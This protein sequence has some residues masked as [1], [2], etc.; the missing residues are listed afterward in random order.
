MK[1]TDYYRYADKVAKGKICACLYVRQACERFICDLKRKDLIFRKDK[2]DRGLMFINTLKHFAGKSSGNPFILEPFQAFIVANLLGW[3]WKKTGFRRFTS[4]YIEMARKGGKTA[5][6]AALAMYF[7]LGDEEDAAEVDIAAND[8]DQAKICFSFIQQYSRQL[9]SK[10]KYLKVLRSSVEMPMNASKVN[11]F[12]GNDKGKD[13]F[14]AS[15]GIIDEYHSAPNT[16]MRDVI[17]SSMGMRE[18]PMLLTITSAGFDKTLPCYALRTTCAEILKGLKTDDS[19]FCIIFTLDEEDDWRDPGVWVKSNPNLGKTVTE[20]Y[21]REQVNSAINNPGEELSVRTKNLGQWLSSAD[22]WIPEHYIMGC[23][24]DVRLE[25]FEG[26][27]VWCGAD[28]AVV[29][30]MT[31]F[32]YML[33]REDDPKLY[34]KT[35]YYLPESALNDSPNKDKYM[36]WK[37]NGFLKLTPGN[38]TDYQWITNDIMETSR[39]MMIHKIFYDRYNAVSWVTQCTELGL[40][41]EE[42]SQTLGNFNRPTREFERLCRSDGLVIDN[43][44]ITRW[45]FTNVALKHDHNGNAKPDKGLGRARKIDGVISML[46]ALGGYL[47]TPAVDVSIY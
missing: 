16:R 10:G 15:V 35:I 6:I 21:L 12:S 38:V 43:N 18:N 30:D 40:P 23:S 28:L 7:F 36:G 47:I 4:A 22:I 41:M 3:Y 31:A 9:D 19:L 46:E 11:V 34:F 8:F 27:D 25:D 37:R 17:K 20:K 5:L 2:V 24:A 42:Y 1:K 14:N 26:A 33:K 39:G 45:M 13:G 29:D 44:P 32:T